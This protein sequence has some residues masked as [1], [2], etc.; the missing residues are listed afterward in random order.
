MSAK[1]YRE[2]VS[3]YRETLDLLG[4]YRGPCGLCGVFPDARH[5]QAD[6]ITGAVLAGDTPEAVAGDYLPGGRADA[7]RAVYEITVANL[8]AHPRLH[9]MARRHAARVDWDVWADLTDQPTKETP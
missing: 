4:P 3:R 6:A 8:A 5:R 2:A 9:S 1:S 7:G